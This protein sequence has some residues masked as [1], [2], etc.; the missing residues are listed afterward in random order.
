MRQRNALTLTAIA[1][2]VK[3]K[4]FHMGTSQGTLS[5]GLRPETLV[6]YRPSCDYPGYDY[7]EALVPGV[8]PATQKHLPAPTASQWRIL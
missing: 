3:L 4:I 7:K 6:R 2:F 8:G 1:V 5:S